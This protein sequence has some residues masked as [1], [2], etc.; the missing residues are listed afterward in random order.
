M[1]APEADKMQFV[2]AQNAG[3][4]LLEFKIFLGE[5]APRPLSSRLSFLHPLEHLRPLNKNLPTLWI[6]FFFRSDVDGKTYK[7]ITK[8]QSQKPVY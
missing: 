8:P 5:H 2:S 3:N 4:G 6:F 7:H 1:E